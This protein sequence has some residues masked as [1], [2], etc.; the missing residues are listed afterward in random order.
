MLAAAPHVSGCCGSQGVPS[1]PSATSLALGWLPVQLLAH[2][3]L[4]RPFSSKTLL[5][6][7]WGCCTQLLE[8]AL[9]MDRAQSH[10]LLQGLQHGLTRKGRG[11]GGADPAMH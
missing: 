7:L 1:N 5:M 6:S 11:H 2:H 4:L 10:G 8:A 9:D 3:G